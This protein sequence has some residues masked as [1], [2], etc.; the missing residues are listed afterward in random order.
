[1]D[2]VQ[3]KVDI[4]AHKVKLLIEMFDS[5]FKKWLP[6]FWKEKGA[7]L[8]K[9]EYYEKNFTFR[10]DHANFADMNHPLSSRVIVDKLADEFEI[11][12]SFKEACVHFQIYSY[13]D[14]IELH[15]LEK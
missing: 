6:F 11:M 7:I 5:L 8:T 13:K 9:D 3:E 1:M 4:L 12:F 10:Q 14:H 2:A 15:V